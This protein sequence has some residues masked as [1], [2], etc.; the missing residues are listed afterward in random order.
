MSSLDD[1]LEVLFTLARNE[2]KAKG[3]TEGREHLVIDGIHE[4]IYCSE[5]LAVPANMTISDVLALHR[6]T[7]RIKTTT[8]LY[9][10]LWAKKKDETAALDGMEGPDIDERRA[11]LKEM[12][13]LYRFALDHPQIIEKEVEMSLMRSAG[14]AR[15]SCRPS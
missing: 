11:F 9:S 8:K 12:R 6:K 2:A 3:I 4:C 13:R 10:E 14:A 7:C 1:P 15:Q 5:K